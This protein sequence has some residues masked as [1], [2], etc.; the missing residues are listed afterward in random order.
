MLSWLRLPRR[1]ASGKALASEP[2]GLDAF[3]SEEVPAVSASTPEQGSSKNLQF[4]VGSLLVLVA[5]QA[6]PSAL[7][8]RS[9]LLKSAEPA[10][11]AAQPE[12]T[13][14][15]SA[16]PT[17]PAT[18]GCEPVPMNPTPVDSATSATSGTSRGAPPAAPAAVPPAS[19]Q[20]LAGMLSV[21]APV[22]LRVFEKGRLVGTTEAE[23]TMLPQGTHQLEFVNEAV[24]FVA[25]RT[26]TIKAGATSSVKLDAPPG[27]LHINAVPWAEVWIDGERIGD[28][29][30]GNL[31]AK[32]GTREIV[33]K[34]PELGERRTTATVT[35]KEPVRIS[36]DLRKK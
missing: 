1:Q 21:S 4:V 31:Q 2:E 33:F 3:T 36:M 28:T 19:S 34:H 22:P 23:S 13:L 6:Y 5:L 18:A 30:I 32:I 10:A 25:R 12:A 26:V 16:A 9:T 8:L 14:A 24:G 20:L 29:P 7:W 11:S 15:A 35:L 17:P 27:T